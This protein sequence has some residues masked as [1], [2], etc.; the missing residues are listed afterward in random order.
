MKNLILITFLLS[1]TTVFAQRANVT[2]LDSHIESKEL[3]KNYDVNRGSTHKSS[4]PDK[5]FRDE[6]LSGVDSIQKWDELK[7]DIFFMDLKSRSLADL[8][9]KYP[10][11][12]IAEL[13]S[14]KD[15]R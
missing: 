8:K 5:D 13:K 1:T 6:V 2:I 11:L 4:L 12:T 10:E 3:E 14:L 9:K 7:K 15:R